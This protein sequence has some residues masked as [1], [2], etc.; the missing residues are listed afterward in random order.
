[1]EEGGRHKT[2]PQW[3]WC[4]YLSHYLL[5]ICGTAVAEL[6]CP[7]LPAL[8]AT[9]QHQDDGQNE[10]NTSQA[11]YYTTHNLWSVERC[12]APCV[13]VAISSGICTCG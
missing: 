2:G 10:R 4:L 5:I 8:V 11:A 12:S 3:R 6:K 1:M 7:A 13:G 9:K